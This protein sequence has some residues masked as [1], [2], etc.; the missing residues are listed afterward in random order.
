M[1]YLDVMYNIM[2]NITL[3]KNTNKNINKNRCMAQ[4]Q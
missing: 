2:K 3:L 4:N 1:L